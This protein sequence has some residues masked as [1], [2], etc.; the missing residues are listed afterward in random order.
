M[1]Y[2]R[3]HRWTHSTQPVVTTTAQLAR[4]ATGQP[5][6]SDRCVQISFLTRI[7]MAQAQHLPVRTCDCAPVGQTY[8]EAPIKTQRRPTRAVRCFGSPTS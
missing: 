6:L 4:A 7:T 2:A 5:N 8:A 3:L 1:S